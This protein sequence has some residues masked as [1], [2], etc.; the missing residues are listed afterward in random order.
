M[1]DRDV[2]YLTVLGPFRDILCGPKADGPYGAKKAHGGSGPLISRNLLEE[3][4]YNTLEG[5]NTMVADGADSS[6]RINCSSDGRYPPS[7]KK[8]AKGV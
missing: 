1:A 2:P 3:A 5:Q 4:A 6:C 8:K 7:Q